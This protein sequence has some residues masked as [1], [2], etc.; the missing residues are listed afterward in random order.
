MIPGHSSCWMQPRSNQRGE[1]AW[2]G[3][4]ETLM[5]FLAT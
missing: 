1:R 5:A 2:S 4:T 3:R